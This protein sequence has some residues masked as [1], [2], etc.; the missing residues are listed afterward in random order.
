MNYETTT[1]SAS[2]V[3]A[4]C[5]IVGV[6]DRGKLGPAAKDVDEASGGWLAMQIRRGDVTSKLGKVSLL[7]AP[8]G[9]K[10]ERVA[11]VGLGKSGDINAVRF[12]KAVA[13][14]M[15]AVIER[16]VKSLVFGL[17]LE[18]IIETSAYC[19]ARHISELIASAS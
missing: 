10:A 15:E 12:R 14:A 5:L 9:V 3:A 17:A 4:D 13:G 2:R 6:Y 19:K 8:E 18:D 1:R 7:P 11:V 16:K